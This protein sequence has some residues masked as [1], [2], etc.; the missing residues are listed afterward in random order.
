M[1]SAD[2]RE[3]QARKKA[4]RREMG[5][6]QTEIET[7]LNDV[8]TSVSDRARFGYWVEKYPLCIAG[9]ALLTGFLLARRFG[10]GKH[11]GDSKSGS[12]GSGGVLTGLL[13]D[14]FKK[15]ATRRIVNFIIQQ[16]EESIDNRKAKTE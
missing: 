7:S 10:G 1:K 2:I 5:Q 11:S 6:I 8:R 16:I 3:L 12:G 15:L 14:E 13:M 4:L 9:S